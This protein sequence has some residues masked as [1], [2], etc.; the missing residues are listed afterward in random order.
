MSH[1]DRKCP[2]FEMVSWD[3]CRTFESVAVFEVAR[4]CCRECPTLLR[5]VPISELSSGTNV[6][7]FASS[8][9]SIAL[10]EFPICVHL[11]SHFSSD[12]PSF[13]RVSWDEC[14]TFESIV[15]FLAGS[16]NLKAMSHT[17]VVCPTFQTVPWN[18]CR[19]FRNFFSFYCPSR[20]PHL[21]SAR[22]SLR[23]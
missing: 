20:I 16:C 7:L 8:S 5:Y 10:P 3:E 17:D 6:A 9:V 2:S 23:Q 14:R 22:V 21:H 11:M 1:F 12:C 19:T 15:V 13:M 4:V 18:A